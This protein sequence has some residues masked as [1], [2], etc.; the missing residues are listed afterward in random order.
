MFIVPDLKQVLNYPSLRRGL[1][2]EDTFREVYR[3]VVNKFRIY[4]STDKFSNDL[5]TMKHRRTRFK[6]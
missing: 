1:L 6:S 5:S 2:C 3:R 4:V